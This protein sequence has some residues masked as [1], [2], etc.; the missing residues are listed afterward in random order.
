MWGRSVGI[1]QTPSLPDSNDDCDY[2]IE[3]FNDFI[4]ER[5]DTWK[6]TRLQ[7]NTSKIP[8]NQYF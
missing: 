6:A 2:T 3:Q 4:K 1:S 7:G 8:S 5:I